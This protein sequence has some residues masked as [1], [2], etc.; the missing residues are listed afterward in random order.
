MLTGKTENHITWRG[1]PNHGGSMLSFYYFIFFGINPLVLREMRSD[2][3]E[4]NRIVSKFGQRIVSTRNL[5]I[6]LF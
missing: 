5:V 6:I 1:K 2:N 4:F 3:P